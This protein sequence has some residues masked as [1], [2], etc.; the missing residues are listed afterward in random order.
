MRALGLHQPWASLI[1]QGIKTV[2]TRDWS[3]TYRGPLA[4]HAN[5]AWTQEQHDR[6]LE[7]SDEFGAER[8]APLP[9]WQP[10]RLRRATDLPPLGAVVAICTLHTV[11][12]FEGDVDGVWIRTPEGGT[13]PVSSDNESAGDCG[14]GRFGWV[15]ARVWRLATPY[16]LRGQQGLWTPKTREI[17]DLRA[18][19]G[20]WLVPDED[21]EPEAP[22][23]DARDVDA[24]PRSFEP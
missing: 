4:I 7:F 9:T 8:F 2:E 5:V 24:R 6:W 21:A 14:P 23:D 20:V 17:A 22:F 19:P 10:K 13:I 3:T 12:A 18:A 1:A 15:L 11:G 16:P